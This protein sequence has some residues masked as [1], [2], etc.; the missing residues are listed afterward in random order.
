MT[1]LPPE[2]ALER[3][4][5]WAL[6]AGTWLGSAVVAV[7]LA[8]SFWSPVGAD[9]ELAGVALFILLPVAR[10]A[11]MLFGFARRREH[12]F[13]VLA[14]LVLAIIAAGTVLGY[15]TRAVT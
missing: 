14:A 15:V 9:V 7:G 6:S 4:L 11:L 5:A 13:A 8:A 3:R 2:D 12:L 10:V 1:S